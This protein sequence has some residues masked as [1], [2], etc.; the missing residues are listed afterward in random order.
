MMI[1]LPP[2]RAAASATYALLMIDDDA[3][4]IT[5]DHDKPAPATTITP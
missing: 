3:A 5:I 1:A 4:V 2:A